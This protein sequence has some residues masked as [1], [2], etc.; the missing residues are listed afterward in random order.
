MSKYV[1]GVYEKAMPNTLS[2]E[3]KLSY[4]KEIG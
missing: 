3:E 2:F 1:L 4:A